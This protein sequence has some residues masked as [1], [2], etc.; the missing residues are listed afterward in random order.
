MT[1]AELAGAAFYE[2]TYVGGRREVVPALTYTALPPAA[3]AWTTAWPL[4]RV[5]AI[6]LRDAARKRRA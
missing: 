2:I 1:L 6:R 3:L 5:E 4:S